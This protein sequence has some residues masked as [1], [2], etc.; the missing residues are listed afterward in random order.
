MANNNYHWR[1]SALTPKLLF[2]NAY[3]ALPLLL[4][5][6]HFCQWTIAI[7]VICGVFF[8]LCELFKYSPIG[9]CLKFRSLLV[10]NKKVISDDAF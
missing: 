4:M 6:V 1:N 2:I 8:L 9:L 7:N 3:M 5:A 10:G